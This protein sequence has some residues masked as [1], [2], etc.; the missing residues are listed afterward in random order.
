[1]SNEFISAINALADKLGFAIDWTAENMLPVVQELIH[2]YARYLIVDSVFG[3]FWSLFVFALG[4]FGLT[5]TVK[6][7]KN[8]T[9]AYHDVFGGELSGFGLSIVIFSA[10]LILFGFFALTFYASATLQLIFNPEIF[11]AQKLLE[12][13]KTG[14]E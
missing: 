14:V 6:S 2:R 10:I 9:W 3:L 1:M 8:K 12:L 11:T 13:I 5:K 4:L 7:F